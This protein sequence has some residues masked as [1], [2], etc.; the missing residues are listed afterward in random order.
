MK[1][2]K[3]LYIKKEDKTGADSDMDPLLCFDY[4]T[5]VPAIFVTYGE[6]YTWTGCISRPFP[7]EHAAL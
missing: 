5:I 4:A 3:R 1:K 2:R 6:L 7:E